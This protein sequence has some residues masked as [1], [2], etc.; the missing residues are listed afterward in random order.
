MLNDMIKQTFEKILARKESLKDTDKMNI[1][2]DEL[3]IIVKKYDSQGK[4]YEIIQ[5]NQ[6]K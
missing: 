4:E 6:E 1:L 5:H 3:E 2:R